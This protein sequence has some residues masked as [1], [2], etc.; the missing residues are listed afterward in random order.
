MAA[1]RTHI[2]RAARQRAGAAAPVAVGRSAKAQAYGLGGGSGLVQEAL[3]LL[4]TPF[5]T[6]AWAGVPPAGDH[7]LKPGA[8]GEH[9]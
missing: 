2:P 9:L 1:L 4:V 6:A 3:D 7:E 8:G 5:D